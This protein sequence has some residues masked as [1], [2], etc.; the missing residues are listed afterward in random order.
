MPAEGQAFLPVVV[1]HVANVSSRR[2]VA[3]ARRTRFGL[4]PPSGQALPGSSFTA[5]AVVPQ[6][7]SLAELGLCLHKNTLPPTR[8]NIFMSPTTPIR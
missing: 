8:R 1:G 3:A 5:G 6:Y 7:A 4:F 2:R